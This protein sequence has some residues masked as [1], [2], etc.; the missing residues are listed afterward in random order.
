MGRSRSGTAFALQGGMNSREWLGVTNQQA[1]QFFFEHLRDVVPSE[2]PTGELLYNA[3]ILAHFATTS[4][5][6]TTTFPPSPTSL[7]FV[8]DVFVMDRSQHA[9]PE[10]M[11]AAGSQCLV[12][13]G[14]F[15][16][17]QERRHNVE[18]YAGL[19][20]SFY[21]RAAQYGRDQARSRMMMAM[22][23]HFDYWRRQHHRLA[24]ELRDVALLVNGQAQNQDVDETGL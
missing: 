9:D 3:S 11:E 8:F 6:S 7:G 22:A 4:T 13:T 19:G 17:Q 5:G 23:R 1:L 10:I 21:D 12:L 16:E 24:L 14:F 20:A 18:W 15:Q 2:P